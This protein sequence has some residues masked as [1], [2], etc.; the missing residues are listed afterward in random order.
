MNLKKLLK[1]IKLNE[2]AISVILGILVVTTVGILTFKYFTANNDGEIKEGTKT[3]EKA[4]AGKTYTVKKG[5]TLWSISEEAY[6]S[7]YNWI[8]IAKENNLTS[9]ND[10]SEGQELRLPSVEPKEETTIA[11]ADEE[12][13]D[14]TIESNTYT[15]KKGDTL[16]AIA[17]SAYG[18]GY[19][20][21]E[22]AKANNLVNPDII[23]SGNVLTLPR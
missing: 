18:D 14:T 22:I 1:N 12:I 13:N 4:E 11:V 9:P 7:G 23:H 17:V 10:I 2:T 20:W 19:K 8:D 5:Q 15:V 3:E 6:D 16:W 21:I